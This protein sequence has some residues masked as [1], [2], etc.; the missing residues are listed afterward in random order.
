MDKKLHVE[1]MMCQ[2]C[3]KHVK[4]ALEAVDGVA[5]ADVDLEGK[6]AVVHLTHDVAD[7]V[8]VAAVVA[9]DYE[10]EIVA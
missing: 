7:D 5:S 10:A 3:V 6:S 9:E 1:G 2:K 4:D 8:L